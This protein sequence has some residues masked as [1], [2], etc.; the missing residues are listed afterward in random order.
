MWRPEK[1]HFVA[2]PFCAVLSAGNPSTVQAADPQPD[3]CAL[4]VENDLFG[5]GT[6]Q[7]YTHGT[8][9][10]CIAAPNQ[11]PTWAKRNAETVHGEA[12]R[13]LSYVF[14]LGQ[15]I[16]TPEDIT[17][18]IPD[19]ND[20]P[21]AGWTYVS[22][23]VVAEDTAR[24]L[25]HNL[26]LDVG[27]VGDLSLAGETQTRWHELIG[28]TKP[29]GWDHQLKN[30]PGIVLT[31]QASRP[32]PIDLGMDWL[33]LDVTPSAGVALGNVETYASLGIM[34]RLGTHLD[35]DYGPPR[36][37]P[38]LPGAGLVKRDD[39]WGWYVFG[40]VQGR[41]VARNIFLD[42]NTFQDSPSV[43]RLPFIADIQAGV[44]VT[45]GQ[46]RLSYTQI[47]RTKEF[48]TQEGFNRFGAL[49]FS[50]FF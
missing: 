26:S 11:V 34:G 17:R 36:I 18:T 39:S 19:P 48:K 7:H 46:F 12:T 24:N 35:I 20:R 5:S 30:E 2:I 50:F 38:S 42:G 32:T 21:Y 23:G 8:R 45:Y 44:A 9:I 6:D 33:E 47:I 1:H 27:I 14:A 22:L 49:T 15:N 40:G 4:L 43:E 28:A 31:Y 37:R 41:A 3:V 16:Y 29:E 10:T 13:S 25:L